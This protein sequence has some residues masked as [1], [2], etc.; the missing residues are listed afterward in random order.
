VTIQTQELRILQLRLYGSEHTHHLLHLCANDRDVQKVKLNSLVPGLVGRLLDEEDRPFVWAV[1]VFGDYLDSH[2]HPERGGFT[3]PA[4]DSLEEGELLANEPSLAA[5]RKGIVPSI[6]EALKPFLEPLQTRTRERVQQYVE[7]QAPE[8]RA[9]L[10]HTDLAQRLSPDVSES[11][12]ERFLHSE[13]RDLELQVRKE[14]AE[15]IAKAEIDELPDEF[16]RKLIDVS[17]AN[18][19]KYVVERRHVLEVLSRSL[20]RKPDGRYQLEESIHKLIFPMRATSDDVLEH[21]L[22]V[23]DDRLAY[24]AYLA[25]DVRL[26][27]QEAIVNESDERPDVVVFNNAF[28][29]SESAPPL[30]SV[31]ILEFKRPARK[32]NTDEKN[33]ITQ[34]YMYIRKIR[35]GTALDRNG[36]P[37]T[38]AAA[39]PFYC[40]ILC[41]LTPSM[42]RVAENM[43]LKLTPDSLGYFGFNETLRA[44]V[45]VI[46]YDKMVED[47]KKRNRAFFARLNMPL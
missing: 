37:I 20:A 21:N 39:T 40:Y 47:A 38:I 27:E 1:F 19:V 42:C 33:P 43:G 46:G 7:S 18:L 23:I 5:I 44:Y 6:L 16:V 11:E 12:L 3:I 25:S 32:D 45:E 34:V 15:L 26:S 36:R 13:K 8:Y 35:E 41:D 31:V 29:L 4:D 14:G 30:S 9:V 2:V 22:W 10:K 28:A 24:H 17:Q